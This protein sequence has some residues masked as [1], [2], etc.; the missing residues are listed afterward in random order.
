MH[1]IQCWLRPRWESYKLSPDPR[2]VGR[3]LHLPQEPHMCHTRPFSV[4]KLPQPHKTSPIRL[5]MSAAIATVWFYVLYKV[6]AFCQ[7]LLDD[8][9]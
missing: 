1:Q 2:L 3:G 5:C 4:K 9:D 8:Y 6:I 7:L